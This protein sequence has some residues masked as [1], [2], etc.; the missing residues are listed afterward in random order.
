MEKKQRLGQYYSISFLIF[1]L[2]DRDRDFHDF[3]A[4]VEPFGRNMVASVRLARVCI[5]RQRRASQLVVRA[6][7]ISS[8]RS[9]TPFLN[10]H[11]CCLLSDFS[12]AARFSQII[13]QALTPEQSERHFHTHLFLRAVGLSVTTRLVH[14]QLAQPD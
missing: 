11:S 7:H 6:A 9:L 14:P 13:P 10:S 1:L 3:A 2:F 8:G 5:H 12:E 4:A